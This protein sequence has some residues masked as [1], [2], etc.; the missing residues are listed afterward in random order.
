MLPL[1][2]RGLAALVIV[3]IGVTATVVTYVH[4]NP[5][6][7][8]PIVDINTGRVA[9]G[10][11]VTIRGTILYMIVLMMGP[12]DQFLTV[13][14]RQN[15]VSFAWFHS[16]VYLGWVIIAAGT[17]TSNHS[18]SHAYWVEHVWLFA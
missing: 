4:D 8:T 18:L 9:V 2:R 5:P 1:H 17:V 3:V 10:E 16:R 6:G 12:Y 15:N 14:D 13:G 11:N 7:T